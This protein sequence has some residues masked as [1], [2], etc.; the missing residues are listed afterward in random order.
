MHYT[1]GINVPTNKISRE[2]R[3]DIQSA[4]RYTGLFWPRLD[5][6]KQISADMQEIEWK[7]LRR[8][9]AASSARALAK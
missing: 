6:L 8:N 9:A 4:L 7:M 3:D 1:Y 2:G 5:R